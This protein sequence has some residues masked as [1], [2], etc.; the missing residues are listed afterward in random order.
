MSCYENHSLPVRVTSGVRAAVNE[1]PGG[2]RS[3]IRM[4]WQMKIAWACCVAFSAFLGALLQNTTVGEHVAWYAG[5]TVVW[6]VV[7]AVFAAWLD[8]VDN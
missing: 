6:T 2:V 5:F 4:Q 7:F 1:I 8:T 3:F